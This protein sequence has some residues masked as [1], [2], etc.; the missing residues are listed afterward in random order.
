M[1]AAVRVQRK[2][3]LSAANGQIQ[4]RDDGSPVATAFH[5][6]KI[7]SGSFTDYPQGR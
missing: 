4:F 5:V 1:A 6:W 3:D 2:F 7:Q